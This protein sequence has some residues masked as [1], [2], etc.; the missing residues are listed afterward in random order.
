MIGSDG[1]V[2][3][4]VEE[5]PTDSPNSKKFR[6]KA[7]DAFNGSHIRDASFQ[8]I[9][10][11]KSGE[12]VL[13]SH[14]F[15]NVTVQGDTVLLSGLRKDVDVWRFRSKDEPLEGKCIALA[16]AY[17]GPLNE[18]STPYA[19][20]S[21]KFLVLDTNKM[22]DP[23]DPEAR[24]DDLRVDVEGAEMGKFVAEKGKSTVL[25]CKVTDLKTMTSVEG[26]N[27]QW[28][29]QRK[30]SLPVDTSSLA[31]ELEIS[32][33]P[34]GS[35]LRLNGLRDTASGVQV[36]CI[37]TNRTAVADGQPG[38]LKPGELIYSQPVFFDIKPTEKPDKEPRFSGAY[39]LSVVPEADPER[40]YT[41]VV[42]GLGPDGKLSATTGSNVVLDAQLVDEKTGEQVPK[43]DAAGRIFFGIE[44]QYTD[45]SPAPINALADHV[46]IDSRTG[47]I[48]LNGYR[49][50]MD[51]PKKGDLRFRVVAER[52]TLSPDDEV[53][54]EGLPRGQLRKPSRQR[55]VSPLIIVV[56]D[57]TAREDSRE[58]VVQL[59]V[60][61]PVVLGLSK[62]HTLPVTA[63]QDVTLICRDRGTDEGKDDLLYGWEVSLRNGHRVPMAGILAESVQESG[64]T[65]R[66]RKLLEQKATLLG[67]C[68]VAR[69]A[70]NS[71][72]YYSRYFA[73]GPKCEDA[74]PFKVGV[75]EV[76][77]A[78]ADTRMFRCSATDPKTGSQLTNSTHYW[79]FVSSSGETVIPGHLFESVEISGDSIVLGRL[80]GDLDL[81]K[82][83]DKEGPIDGQCV[84]LTGGEDP[85][86]STSD[87]FIRID[88]SKEDP[89]KPAFVGP[90]E[91]GDEKPETVVQ[92]PINGTVSLGEGESTTLK[93][94]GIDVYTGTAIS[95]LAVEWEI[96]THDNRPVDTSAVADKV[97]ILPDGSL[98]LTGLRDTAAGIRA[99]CVLMNKTTPVSGDET[100]PKAGGILPPGTSRPGNFIDF[101]IKPLEEPTKPNYT[102]VADLV[103]SP[104]DKLYNRYRV[105]IDGLRESD[106]LKGAQG[107]TVDLRAKVF[108]AL[109]NEDLQ[110]PSEN[111]R[112]GLE[113]T[114]SDG[115]PAPLS[116]LADS[117]TVD[118]ATGSIKLEGFQGDLQNS[119]KDNLRFRVIAEITQPRKETA[120]Y[121]REP[122][123]ERI[124]SP[125]YA[126]VVTNP[127]GTPLKDEREPARKYE[128]LHPIVRGLSAGGN[129]PTEGEPQVTLRCEVHSSTMKEEDLV[130]GW[131]VRTAS[132]QPMP[133][134]GVVAD[135]VRQSGN[136]I[137]FT[138]LRKPEVRASGRCVVSPKADSSIKYYSP[139][140]EIGL[141]SKQDKDSKVTVKVQEIPQPSPDRRKFVCNAEGEFVIW[142]IRMAR[143][144]RKLLIGF[145]I[146]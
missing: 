88:V 55:F 31:E 27:Y 109:T 85:T 96:R 117:V 146:V 28:K 143:M 64:N 40:K 95:G 57:G 39:E 29:L 97:E 45:G 121:I 110:T 53:P 42:G 116:A 133:M 58:E 128:I 137:T 84:V 67:R 119:Q 48:I 126:V 77:T 91:F 138:G 141:D 98:R 81:S 12:I 115:S 79:Q 35:T 74:G 52:I 30:D 44:A 8:W 78:D 100:D 3:S 129:L 25:T 130:F 11:T 59:P 24:N 136:A 33:Q 89:K 105:F 17:S 60:L 9:F 50:D 120:G 101:D 36:Q 124:A 6:C 61:T 10:T 46:Q 15:A 41:V 103:T 104:D 131:E 47:K 86:K 2:K 139:Y 43:E 20:P 108:D 135:T 118:A 99:R 66:L 80:R 4:I 125:F 37:V 49:G 107:E 65:L 70:G 132:G 21:D 145:A 16:P 102:G 134:T 123:M 144:R 51:E 92:G 106:T 76:P 63:G 54:D 82:L 90:A 83:A 5:L 127:D 87:G 69:K 23:T 1:R 26:L 7:Y 73:I 22:V 93:C 62:C 19:Y 122:T 71:A 113:V 114:H 72:R 111:I 142:P 14:L 32:E 18:T 34:N 13:P 56:E 140:F 68:V 75:F 94:E 38:P 112:F